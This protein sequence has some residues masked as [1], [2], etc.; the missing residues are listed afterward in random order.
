MPTAGVEPLGHGDGV[1]AGHG[2]DDEQHVVGLDLAL[3]RLQLLEHR[4]VDV[5]P[6]GGVEDERG[7]TARRRLLARGATDLDAASARRRP[8]PGTPS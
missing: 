1:L 7:Q 2:V 8:G 5:Q 3:D 4:L 6:A